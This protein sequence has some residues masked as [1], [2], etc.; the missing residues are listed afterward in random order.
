MDQI[1]ILYAED[2]KEPLE[3]FELR[4]ASN[5]E[6][7]RYYTR[8]PNGKYE[9][10]KVLFKDIKSVHVYQETS[11][12]VYIDVEKYQLSKWYVD[13][14]TIEDLISLEEETHNGLIIDNGEIVIYDDYVE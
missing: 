2:D 10:R 12:Y 11:E 14:N 4:A 8:L 1:R 13:I 3:R 5:S 7:C 9:Y 6:G